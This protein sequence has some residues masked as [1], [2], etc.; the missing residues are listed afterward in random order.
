MPTKI[1]V[2]VDR[3]GL[4]QRNAEQ[5]SANRRAQLELEVQRDVEEAAEPLRETRLL[6]EGLDAEGRR[7]F[8][9]TPGSEGI[10]PDPAAFRKGK[11]VY[12]GPTYPPIELTI[13]DP[14]ADDEIPTGSG[15]IYTESVYYTE[16]YLVV[17]D[18]IRRGAS[19]SVSSS[20][21]YYLAI[22][23]HRNYYLITY[24]TPG[25][26]LADRQ[27]VYQGYLMNDVSY[28]PDA[29]PNGAHAITVGAV[30]TQV[31]TTG[32]AVLEV[33]SQS[34]ITVAKR[35]RID[36]PL[37]TL[38]F[39]LK[40]INDGE[41]L[42]FNVGLA[43]IIIAASWAGFDSYIRF[44]SYGVVNYIAN[45][46]GDFADWTHVAVVFVSGTY[47]F[48]FSGQLVYSY[49]TPNPRAI[50]GPATFSLPT[51]I[52]VP[53]TFSLSSLRIVNRAVYRANFTPPAVI[54]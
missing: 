8:G 26:T 4:L 54:R 15:S 24:P 30:R 32:A 49:T 14:L 34:D 28:S 12:F 10:V 19:T 11:K 18:T 53:S 31:V 27:V 13:D 5:Q 2:V 9:A 41:Y 25:A 37:V 45:T 38:E 50:F 51:E 21:T 29:G 20:R 43:Q 6:A 46:L 23:S 52:N 33:S 40:V 47:H 16:N 36:A 1:N 35:A 48:Y 44:A 42:M 3:G 39:Y 7:R 22:R 17:Q